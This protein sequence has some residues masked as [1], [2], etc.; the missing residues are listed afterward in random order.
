MGRNFNM[1]KRTVTSLCLRAALTPLKLLPMKK[2]RVLFT[3]YLEKQYSCNP[4]YISEE[5]KRMYGD[6]LEI[7]WLFRHPENFKYLEEQG[8]RVLGTKNLQS[9]LFAMTSRV[10]VSNTYFKPSLP[11]RRNQF[12]LYT[13]HGGGAY[14]KVGDSKKQN[15]IEKFYTHIRE[16]GGKLYLSSSDFF[17]ENVVRDSFHYKGEVL[18][19]GMPRNDMLINGLPEEKKALIREKIGLKDGE[20]LVLYA[21]TYR[22]DTCVHAFN[23]DYARLCENLSRRFGGKYVCGYRSHHVTMYKPQNGADAGA[24]NLTDYPDMQEL[25]AVCD[26]LV[27]DF[28]SSIWDAAVGGVKALLYF[29][30]MDEFDMEKDFFTDVRSWPFPLAKNE[31]ELEKNILEFDENAYKAACG[32][33]LKSLGSTESGRASYYAAKRIGFEMGLEEDYDR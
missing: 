15:F 7:G 2:N 33:H 20:K 4:R 3:A 13:W 12:I 8:I 29:T 21:P 31:E 14:K 19:K 18:S 16:S 22:K 23:P 11:R 1:L 30:D 26:V 32:E 5:L 24:L 6:R 27:T 28:S 10:I 9:T 17:T 25:L